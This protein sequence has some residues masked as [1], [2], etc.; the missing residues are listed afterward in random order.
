LIEALKDTS[1]EVRRGAISAIRCINTNRAIDLF[2]EI[3]KGGVEELKKEL[4]RGL[5]D[6]SD[7]RLTRIFLKALK[8][9]DLSIIAGGFEFFILR[10]EPQTEDVLIRALNK[11]GDES[12]ANHFLGCGNERLSKAGRNWYINNTN[13]INTSYYKNNDWGKRRTS[14]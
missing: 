7:S 12:M 11:Y 14:K 2:F 5:G 1:P 3:S 9:E 4:A 8:D 6:L 13:Y 10:G